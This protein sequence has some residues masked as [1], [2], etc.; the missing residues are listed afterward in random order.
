MTSS[1]PR[2]NF[3]P[4]ARRVHQNKRLHSR[5]LCFCFN[6]LG[7]GTDSTTTQTSLTKCW[8]TLNDSMQLRLRQPLRRFPFDWTLRLNP[9]PLLPNSLP[10]SHNPPNL[11]PDPH[12]PPKPQLPDPNNPVCRVSQDPQVLLCRGRG[13][14]SPLRLTAL[15]N[16]LGTLLPHLQARVGIATQLLSSHARSRWLSRLPDHLKNSGRSTKMTMS[17]FLHLPRHPDRQ[18]LRLG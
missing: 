1:S 18:K 15:H 10:N 5:S 2:S 8:R 12:N 14:L 4:F 6:L 3:C 13:Q 9:H 16:K 11:L 7:L 17:M